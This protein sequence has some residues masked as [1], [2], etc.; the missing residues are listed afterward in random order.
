[1]YQQFLPEL[2]ER[3]LRYVQ[4][5]TASQE[6]SPTAPS[7]P[8]QFELLNLLVD[9]LRSI[10]AQEV[11]STEYGAVLATIPAHEAVQH[12]P[13]VAFLA[14]V[15]TYPGFSGDSVKPIVHRN[16]DGLPIALPDDP[17]RVV[18]SEVSPALRKKAGEDLV[19][20][21]GTTLLGADDKAGVAIIM[22]MA[23]SLI[24]ISEPTRPY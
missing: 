18:S 10:G 17:A 19:T 15:D 13:T 6:N 12:A 16:W 5:H 1:M 2:E 7:T 20:A 3:F 24:H 4:I 14:H 21:S 22:A 9:E 8:R 11:R 23:L